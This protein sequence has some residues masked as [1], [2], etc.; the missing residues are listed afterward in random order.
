MRV[1]IWLSHDQVFRLL[2]NIMVRQ[3]LAIAGDFLDVRLELAQ[4]GD[5][6]DI[7]SPGAVE[8]F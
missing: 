2:N 7:L 6:S 1:Y 4:I 8:R 3:R 5:Y